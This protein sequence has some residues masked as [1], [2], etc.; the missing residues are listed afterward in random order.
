MSAATSLETDGHV[1]PRVTVVTP[2]FNRAD[3]IR[4]TIASV[5]GQTFEDFEYL[6]IDDGSMD[7]TYSVVHS[8]R[9]KRVRYFR[10]ENRGEAGSTNR[11]W[12]MAR[13]EYFAVLSSDD[14]VRPKWLEKCVKF[15]DANPEVLVV[16]PDWTMIDA[17]S[18]PLRD[19]ATLEYDLSSMVAWFSPF[20]GPGAI[21]RRS[22][23]RDILELRNPDY[24]YAPDLDCWL[25]L[26]LRGP[27]S[28]LPENLACWREHQ[29][30]ITVADRS[31]A[32]A[33][34]IV[35]IAEKFFDRP[36]VPDELQR[37]KPYALSRAHST[38]AYVYS[39][40]SPLRAAFSI[41]QAYKASPVEP[42]DMPTY[43]RRYPRPD[44]QALMRLAKASAKFHLKPYVRK[45]WR[46]LPQQVRTTIFSSMRQAGLWPVAIPV[47]EPEHAHPHAQAG[48]TV[49]VPMAALPVAL[50]PGQNPVASPED[51]ARLRALVP[52]LRK[53]LLQ[54]QQTVSPLSPTDN[55]LARLN[56]KLT[57]P[58]ISG[59]GSTI[60]KA[61]DRLPS[62]V[63][64]MVIVPRMSTIGGSETVTSRLLAVLAEQFDV[65][66]LCII[67]PDLNENGDVRSHMGI[68]ALSF[69]GLDKDLLQADREDILDRLLI[70]LRPRRL[71]CINS[72]V[73][74][75][76]LRER[77]GQ[78]AVDSAIYTNIYS[79][80]RLKDGSP[81]AG[82]YYDFL[83][84][85]MEH[86]TAIMAD[87]Q[88]IADKLCKNF[89]LS[90]SQREKLHIIRTP[91]IGFADKDPKAELRRFRH[92][93]SERSLWLSRIAPEKRLDVL[94]TIAHDCPDRQFKV[95]GAT[96]NQNV[97]MSRLQAERNIDVCG[98]FQDLDA[99]PYDEFDSYIFTTSGEGMPISL[100]EM[101]AKGLPI[102]A[103]DVG[104][105]SELIGPDTGWL[106]SDQEADEEYVDALKTI[107]RNPKEAERRVKAAQTYLLANHSRKAFHKALEAVP[108]Y[109]GDGQ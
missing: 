104:G 54:L 86:M 45:G 25:R 69:T 65:D 53:D 21:I 46:L 49:D 103:P 99:I 26:A 74:W 28:R 63:D 85:C 37:L 96:N 48:H 31:R 8:Y 98:E 20:P 40:V 17:A 76:N 5:L 1:P 75:R 109:L 107:H 43:F 29:G 88:V 79:D 7:N 68:K 80:I 87:N 89:G 58:A 77:A 108:H 50:L 55:M 18:Q 84:H 15:M 41:R 3:L 92:Q 101:V 32:R 106:M 64:H 9:D 91:V 4:E 16:Y 82:F 90:E 100:L 10:H 61:L 73:G 94:A 44:R 51:A 60:L 13:G 105:I 81:A 12:A 22:A 36:D 39:D 70:Q 30:S 71:H 6:I 24:R 2:T 14:P 19:I 62:T 11:G 33:K 78:Y 72:Y 83:P 34:E 47:P 102:V 42:E 52:I 66:R 93:S 95:Y 67:S 59:L 27:F 23:V 97:D 38:A 56:R 57:T 35:Q